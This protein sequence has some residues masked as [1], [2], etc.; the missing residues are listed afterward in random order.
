MLPGCEGRR[1]VAGAMQS[2]TVNR[3]A[4]RP[5]ADPRTIWSVALYCLFTMSNHAKSCRHSKAGPANAQQ[6][7]ITKLV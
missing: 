7:L 2:M 6:V 4:L 3:S 5:P 1:T